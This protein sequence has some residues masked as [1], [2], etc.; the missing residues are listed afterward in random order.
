MDRSYRL[1]ELS[2]GALIL[3]AGMFVA[4]SLAP[5]ADASTLQILH[6]FCSQAGC[7]DG[8]DPSAGLIADASGNL[9]G[10]AA[11]GGKHGDGVVFELIRKPH[12]KWAYKVL[13]SFCR[14]QGCG[15]GSTPLAPLIADAAGDFYGTTELGGV[16]QGVVFE[17][18]PGTK[19]GK[20]KLRVLHA[21]CRQALCPDGS[22]PQA[23]LSYAGAASGVPYDGVSPLYGTAPGGGANDGGVAFQLSP[24]AGTM[25]WRQSVIYDFCSQGGSACTDGSAPQGALLVDA[26][27]QLFGTTPG[28]GQNAGGTVFRLRPKARTA[29]WAQTVL[30]DFCGEAGCTDGKEPLAGVLMD[31]GGKLF[32]T[33]LVGGTNCPKE[34]CGVVFKLSNRSANSPYA[35]LYDFCSQA[36]CADGSGTQGGLL[37]DASG[38]LFGTASQGGGNDIDDGGVGGGAVY[39][40]T[41][42][43]LQTLYSFCAQPACADGEYPHSGIIADASGNL[44]GTTLRGGAAGSGTVFELTP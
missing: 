16:G 28:G 44:F 24:V 13:H 40:L 36:D 23:A 34:T 43:T 19:P 20:W 22:S 18:V 39:E 9:Y 33:T 5:T 15:D 12:G 35:V 2:R 4:S 41:G 1:S 25:K 37:M 38:D 11:E 27:S 14:A 32:G 8:L 17:L 10:T 6:S 26:S 29:H 3:C 42:S 21:F 31:A 7:A 30:H